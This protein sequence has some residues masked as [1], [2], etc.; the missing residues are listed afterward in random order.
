MNTMQKVTSA[1]FL[2]GI[3]L[4]VAAAATST[5]YTWGNPRTYIIAAVAAGLTGALLVF[6]FARGG[7][8]ARLQRGAVVLALAAAALTMATAPLYKQVR[9]NPLLEDMRAADIRRT[10]QPE[11][12]AKPEQFDARKQAAM[13]LADSTHGSSPKPN[14]FVGLK[15]SETVTLPNWRARSALAGSELLAGLAIVVV[16][17]LFRRKPRKAN[18]TRGAA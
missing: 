16:L 12:S 5:D 14:P 11:R 9:R 15:L 18:D 13:D 3:A 8:I 4:L 2:L 6:V 1:V 17:S 10:L 7:V